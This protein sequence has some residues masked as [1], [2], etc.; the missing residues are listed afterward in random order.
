MPRDAINLSVLLTRIDD[1]SHAGTIVDRVIV[2][3]LFRYRLLFRY[4]GNTGE[5]L[6][7]FRRVSAVERTTRVQAHA[8]VREEL[9]T[10][11]PQRWIAIDKGNP[12]RR[13]AK[14]SEREEASSR[15]RKELGALFRPVPINSAGYTAHRDRYRSP[16]FLT[17]EYSARPRYDR[18]GRI[19]RERAR[20]ARIVCSDRRMNR[21]SC[22]SRDPRESRGSRSRPRTY[23]TRARLRKAPSA[24]ND[25]A[26]A[27]YRV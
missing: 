5:C 27:S 1:S 20:D 6:S 10:R 4:E 16:R 3:S 23:V 12:S 7:S 24:T 2:C 19:E 13:M 26:D 17:I 15:S 8:F 14:G 22:L 11:R 9:I 18:N 21:T 25:A